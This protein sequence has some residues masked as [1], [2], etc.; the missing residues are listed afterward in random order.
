MD[1]NRPRDGNRGKSV[2]PELKLYKS[3]WGILTVII[4]SILFSELCVKIIL[5]LLK[6][7]VSPPYIALL[8]VPLHIIILSPVLF[9]FI[10]RPLLH[11]IK[12][13]RE[14]ERAL[15]REKDR[16][17]RYLKVAGV[18]VVVLDRDG[19]VELI[20]RKGCDVLGWSED[21][22][23]GRNWFDNFIPGR[24]REEVF[25]EFSHLISGDIESEGYFENPVLTRSGAERT[26]LWHNIILK[27]SG[28]VTGTLSSG[29]DITERKRT[30]AA[31]KESEAR[32]RLVHNTAFDG[33]MIASAQDRIIDCNES[34]ERIFGYT[35]DELVGQEV[36]ILIP[37]RYKRAHKEGL[38]RFLES[39]D[40]KIQ[41]MIME[42]KGIRKNGEVFPL[43]LALNNFTL[44][45]I[46]H[47][48]A[49]IRDI[50]ERKRAE[51]E[52]EMIQSRLSQS[53]K[54]EAIGRF[55]GGIA[56]DFNNILTSIRG[57]AELALED[58]KKTD[59]LYPK[60][61][62][63][64]TS[65]L[66]ASRLTR[67][68]LLF[69]RGQPFELVPLNMNKLIEDLLMMITRIIG[70]DIIISTNL[71][72]NLCLIEADEGNMEQVLMNLAVNAKD[73]MPEGGRLSISTENVII[74]QKKAAAI[75]EALP[76]EAICLTVADTGAGI[77]KELIPRIF[78]PFFTT[79]EAGKGMGFGL[80]I[81]YG[82]VKQHNGW[83]TVSSEHGKGATFKIYFPV[84]TKKRGGEAPPPK[85]PGGSG[86]KIL[87]VD[88][89]QHAREF[90]SV[91]LA[92]HGFMVTTA[93]SAREALDAMEKKDGA[94]ELLLSDVVL[95]DQSGL[96]LAA[97]VREKNPDIKVILTINHIEKEEPPVKA[98]RHVILKKPYSVSSLLKAVVDTLGIKQGGP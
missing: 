25:L 38:K 6:D 67:Q 41:G 97:E 5:H 73:A 95:D 92:E 80:S 96:Q 14:A 10:F 79:K 4:L 21:E 54:M 55:A 57:N 3:P 28:R 81:V 68:L 17:Q 18:I 40:S 24:L 8:D 22:I 34:A 56:H 66:L 89:E 29:E 12:E 62:G 50:T 85:L 27:E 77:E 61:E 20:N 74:D 93:A 51:R 46:I 72:P 43:E 33:I 75:P 60:L 44:G 84:I 32:Y 15:L 49:M 83:I 63:I 36:T 37:D 87:L 98:R 9:L 47:F 76:C 39:G 23:L 53:Q 82:I 2:I 69:S 1:D 65:V 11:I 90:T 86:Q 52:R 16:F 13:R 71:A 94:F 48:T 35:R 42:Y 19:R 59:P 30:E 58:M 7:R 70:E 26:V 64:V 31:L 78:E 91:A 88:G 45:G